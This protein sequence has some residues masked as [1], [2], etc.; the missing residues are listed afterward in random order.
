MSTKM[1]QKS[2][3]EYIEVMRPR[4]TRR[5]REGRSRLIDELCALGDFERKYAIKAA[6]ATDD[7]AGGGM[8]GGARSVLLTV[9]APVALRA[10]S[11][12]PANKTRPFFQCKNNQNKDPY[13]CPPT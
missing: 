11:A 1:S 4:Y 8:R 2:L 12:T 5:G 10:S 13:R 7:A 3:K 9:C 6:P